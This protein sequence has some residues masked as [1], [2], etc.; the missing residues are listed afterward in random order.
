MAQ[1]GRYYEQA[2]PD[3]LTRI[4]VTATAVLE[5]GC[6]AGALG[7]AY[8][9]INPTATYIGVELMPGPAEQ[10]RKVLD[11]VI[12][13]DISELKVLGLPKKINKIDCLIFGDVLEHL[14]DPQKVIK[15]LLPLLKEE[16]QLIACIPN[17]QHWSLI[18][19]LL[20]GKWPQ[21]DQGLFDR[22]HL[23]WFTREGIISLLQSLDL[24]IQDIKPRIF[25]PE[26]AKAFVSAL[27]P[28]LGSL[29]ID[30]QNLFDGVAPLQYV[31]RAGK[32]KVNPIQI[33]GLM[34]SPQ[35]GMNDVRMIQPLRSI[36]S[37]P[38]V[39]VSMAPEKLQ[40]PVT[41]SETAKIMIWQRQLLTYERSLDDIRRIIK[42]GYILI[43]EFD[44]DPNHWPA[45]AKNKNLNFTGT[46]AVQ[47][48]T[49][50]LSKTISRYNPNVEVFENCLERVPNVST[51][52]WCGAGHTKPLKIFFGALNREDDWSRW[53]TPLNNF[54]AQNIQRWE[55]EIVHDINFYEALHTSSKHF[56]PTCNY[57]EYL[58][59]MQECHIALLPL[60]NTSFNNKKS[61]LKFVEAAGCNVAC[62]ASPTVYEN[63][64]IH[65]E[66]GM[67]CSD[68]LKLPE[69]LE[70]WQNNPS[71]AEK[72]AKSAQNWCIKNRLQNQQ[73]IRRLAWYQSLWRRRD[74]LTKELFKRV[75][76]LNI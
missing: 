59:K 64:I 20:H 66:T 61:D 27:S 69:I 11:Y 9:A 1:A 53:I 60:N 22:T 35:A 19:N 58:A 33:C 67:I 14:V 40:V 25:R 26:R 43:S 8:K 56:T 18:T 17:A 38:G 74:E 75:P 47:V 44:D 52:K 28:S 62:I 37:F 16:G 5:I 41:T 21:E 51:N 72:L 30:P 3:L 46:H 2:N 48:S 36:G 34:L 6:G 13:G 29:S 70:E 45:I 7:D 54:L 31:V 68:P 10:A 50:E 49:T 63:T 39:R 23:R 65:N 71:H 4:P 32:Q 73:S 12:E 42:A 55:F 24:Y 76:E 57:T 15:M